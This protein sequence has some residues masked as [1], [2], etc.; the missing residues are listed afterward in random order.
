MDQTHTCVPNYATYTDG[1]GICKA[2]MKDCIECNDGLSCEV[3]K[4]GYY[5]I[6]GI[7]MQACEE[8]C[9]QLPEGYEWADNNQ[10]C[11]ECQVAEQD[12]IC[13]EQCAVGYDIS[14]TKRCR[15]CADLDGENYLVYDPIS[16]KCTIECPQGFQEDPLS[17]LRECRQ[18]LYVYREP[19]CGIDSQVANVRPNEPTTI[20]FSKPFSAIP[21]VAI[22]IVI[23]YFEQPESEL[24]ANS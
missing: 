10:K 16:K 13:V 7:G 23:S 15:T 20:S 5:W 21:R 4:T 14:S 17:N 11:I 9:L 12:E 22:S 2:C 19:L 3:C 6:E 8:V 24:Q 18:K 1:E